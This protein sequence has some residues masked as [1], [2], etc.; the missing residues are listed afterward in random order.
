MDTMAARTAAGRLTD[1]VRRITSSTEVTQNIS[2][3]D[4]KSWIPASLVRLNFRREIAHSA[5]ADRTNRRID[6]TIT[7]RRICFVCIF[8]HRISAYSVKIIYESHLDDEGC[9]PVQEM[10]PHKVRAAQSSCASV[11]RS[12]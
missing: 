10:T 11:W 5:Y 9:H 7:R 12:R 1:A 4:R 3:C 6:P 8:L 2:R